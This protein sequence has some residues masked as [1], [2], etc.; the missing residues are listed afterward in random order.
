MNTAEQEKFQ[1][2]VAAVNGSIVDVVFTPPLPPMQALLL[3]ES[4]D[5]DTIKLEVAGHL[6]ETTVRAIALTPVAGLQ[7]DQPVSS[8][9]K[10]LSVPV[11]T[12]L[13]GRMLNVFGE[14]IDKGK[15]LKEVK[16]RPIYAV[17]PPL[18]Q[19][20]VTPEIIET[21]IKIIDLLAPLEKG[22]KAGLFGGAGVGKTVII[23]ELIN[24]IAGQQKGVSLF[25]GI[26]ERSREA[27]ELYQEMDG[28][29]V[30]DKTVMVFAQM[31]EPSGA[32]FKVGHAALTLAEY[33]RDEQKKDVL[34]L[35]DNIFRFIQAGSEVSGLMG[36]IPSHVGY[37]PTLATELA[38]LEERICSTK[39][40]AIT[41]V[42]AVYVPADD[43][44]DPAASHTFSHLSASV[45]LSR[46]R[47]SQGLYPAMD[48]LV[49]SS[50]ML[51]PDI[52]SDRHYQINHQV[53]KVFAEYEE[54]KD[55]IAMLGLEE[56]SEADRQT[57]AIARRLERF[58]TQPFF[59]TSRF[60]GKEGRSVPLHETLNGCSRILDGEFLDVP[61]KN[62]YMIGSIDEVEK[63]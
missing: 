4:R 12:A 35:I 21:G 26:G 23:T 63:L 3:I 54:L 43:F 9:G 58:L 6:S 56:L 38:E 7:R 46:K 49:S 52:V 10:S 40:G 27:E 30:L 33:F 61:E 31:N 22:G 62:L 41:S 51:T 48:P 18:S 42:Q 5:R 19:R 37:Q 55:I 36:Y 17:P 14:V 39:K 59:T 47:T 13:L 44:T 32:R 29:G 2:R 16:Q 60:T 34:L 11:G 50:N 24:N 28:A 8:N 53:R 1:G 45:V 57:V 15:P 20:T 25:C